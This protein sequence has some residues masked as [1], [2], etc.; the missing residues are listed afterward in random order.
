MVKEQ[1]LDVLEDT[2]YHKIMLYAGILVIAILFYIYAYTSKRIK[3]GQKKKL[4]AS[5]LLTALFIP[6]LNLPW[7]IS[8]SRDVRKV[9]IVSVDALYSRE[10]DDEKNHIFGDDIVYVK[11][12]ENE[13]SLI[14]PRNWSEKHFPKGEH[15]GTVFYSKESKVI[16]YFSPRT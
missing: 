5:S 1:M 15:Y 2:L 10:C 6:L 14:L 11:Q 3:Q 16:L 4:M 12:G 8:A 13:L 7:I 9:Q